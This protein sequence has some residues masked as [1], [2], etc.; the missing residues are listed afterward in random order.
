MLAD[1]PPAQLA[2][3]SNSITKQ[4]EF[5]KWAERVKHGVLRM[6]ATPRGQSSM[7]TDNKSDLLACCQLMTCEEELLFDW[8][9]TM[10]TNP[11]EMKAPRIP[12]LEVGRLQG[13]YK[14]NTDDEE[15]YDVAERP[16][17]S[18]GEVHLMALE[19][20]PYVALARYVSY[21]CVC[22]NFFVLQKVFLL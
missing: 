5:S 8:D 22:H 19:S 13:D 3:K 1:V 15:E 12:T 4:Q 11:P 14:E 21:S 7:T 6:V 2:N 17:W 18:I 16:K 9:I 10:Y 20:Y